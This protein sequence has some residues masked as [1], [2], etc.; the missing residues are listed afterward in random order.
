LISKLQITNEN[1]L[2]AWQLLKQRYNNIRLISMMHVKNLCQIPHVK[3]GDAPSL[4]SLINH[5]SSHFNALQ[6][7]SLNVNVQDLMLNHLILA[8]LDD[9]SQRDWE[10]V[11]APRADIPTSADLITF[12]ETRCRALELI[13]SNQLVRTLPSLPRSSQATDR[14]VSKHTYS[15]VAT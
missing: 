8:S 2:V 11:I 10:I 15:N 12:L 6:A 5:A 7:L 13:Q 4:R 3:K 9:Q 14:R 1:F